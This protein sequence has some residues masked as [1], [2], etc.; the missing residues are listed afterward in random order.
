M[1]KPVN[2]MWITVDNFYYLA[3]PSLGHFKSAIAC[4]FAMKK[5][6]RYQRPYAFN[7]LILY[8]CYIQDTQKK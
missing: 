7:V 4:Q 1:D 3:V 6:P 8:S 5:S 2:S